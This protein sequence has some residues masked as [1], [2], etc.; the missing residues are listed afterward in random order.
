MR[1]TNILITG[2]AGAFDG[3]FIEINLSKFRHKRIAVFS[4]DELK[5]HEIYLSGFN[6]AERGS[7]AP[8]NGRVDRSHSKGGDR[9]E[10]VHKMGGVRDM[11][12]H[13]FR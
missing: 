10:E 3:K 6:H 11:A 7:P 1:K 4:R 12:W 9:D 13:H 8:W 2:G 5:Q